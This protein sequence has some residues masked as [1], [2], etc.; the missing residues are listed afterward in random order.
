MS[1]P[2]VPA[3][4]RPRPPRFCW[5]NRSSAVRLMKPSRV[6]V[7][8]IWPGSTSASSSWSATKSTMA[9]I[10]GEAISSRTAASSSRMTSRRRGRLPRISSSS[11]ISPATSDRSAW[12]FS[13]S[14]PVSR[15]RRRSR[16]PRAWVSVSRTLPSSTRLPLSS[17]SASSGTMSSAGQ[18]RSMSAARAV[19]ESGLVRMRRMTSSMLATATA[20]P[21]SRCARSRAL[22]S[23]K[24]LRRSTT[25][26]RKARKT[27]SASFSPMVRGRPPS[28]ARK[29]TPKLVCSWVNR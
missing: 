22:A 1:S 17:T 13:R 26:S 16:M 19:A 7:T 24:R 10:R 23:R 9:V 18:S 14:S 12:I 21:I 6:M 27:S 28:S 29:L 3:P 5:R 8:T 4:V 25:S 20:R 2:R 15:A 11:V